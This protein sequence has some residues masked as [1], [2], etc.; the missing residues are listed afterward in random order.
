MEQSQA[1]SSSARDEQLLLVLQEM[2]RSLKKMED[3]ITAP[4]VHQSQPEPGENVICS[5]NIS[6]SL[7]IPPQAPTE[8]DVLNIPS[9]QW[10]LVDSSSVPLK[11][12]HRKPWTQEIT[13]WSVPPTVDITATPRKWNLLPRDDSPINWKYYK[14][15]WTDGETVSCGNGVGIPSTDIEKCLSVK[16]EVGDLALLYVPYSQSATTHSF[17]HIREGLVSP[18]YICPWRHPKNPQLRGK[19][20]RIF[21]ALWKVPGD[22]RL[23]L[24]LTLPRDSSKE[25][26]EALITKLA[27]KFEKLRSTRRIFSVIDIDESPSSVTYE[28]GGSASAV[29][30]ESLELNIGPVGP[31]FWPGCIH[32]KAW[33][34]PLSSLPSDLFFNRPPTWRRLIYCRDCTHEFSEALWGLE[35]T[36]TQTIFKLHR[37]HG[38]RTPEMFSNTRNE[39]AFHLSWKEFHEASKNVEDGEASKTVQIQA[40]PPRYKRPRL[41]FSEYGA[42]KNEWTLLV[43]TPMEKVIDKEHIRWKGDLERCS[44]IYGIKIGSLLISTL[45]AI[46]Q[47]LDLALKAWEQVYKELERHLPPRDYYDTLLADEDHLPASIECFW[48]ADRLSDIVPQLDHAIEE[49]S[50]WQHYRINY[51]LIAD[52]HAFAMLGRIEAHVQMINKLRQDFDELGKRAGAITQAIFN[53]TSVKETRESRVLGENV[54]LL[55]YATIVFL[56]LTF[57]TDLLMN[58]SMWSINNMFNTG[59]KGFVIITP[60]LA[61]ITYIIILLLLSSSTRRAFHELGQRMWQGPKGCVTRLKSM[62]SQTKVDRGEEIVSEVMDPEKAT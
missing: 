22:G 43:L 31:Y 50:E 37:D 32:E 20:S 45:S 3:H 11:E 57:C 6:G 41:N 10:C 26:E 60:V 24:H 21:G 48:V 23:D 12:C 42:N 54:R 29:V 1:R 52:E 16:K 19:Y 58:Q 4:S 53:L 38:W 46:D 9:Y 5:S 49:W 8:V 2:Q 56:P 59:I 14:P 27:T 13:P 47:G 44:Q 25:S 33:E 17:A 39:H 51:N 34:N 28:F 55:T 62:M 18:V 15:V 7:S 35:C 40:F 61:L 30:A 36:P